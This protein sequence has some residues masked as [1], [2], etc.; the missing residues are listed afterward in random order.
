MAGEDC[1]HHFT[2][3][4]CG[5]ARLNGLSKGAEEARSHSLEEKPS[6]V[7]LLCSHWPKQHN[8]CLSNSLV[9]PPL[10]LKDGTGAQFYFRKVFSVE[11]KAIL[12]LANW[13][14]SRMAT[15]Y[16]EWERIRETDWLVRNTTL[17]CSPKHEN[18]FLPLTKA[19]C[20]LCTCPSK[21]SKGHVLLFGLVSATQTYHALIC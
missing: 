5:V 17:P 2:N 18:A 4:N 15:Q 16:M 1:N 9:H 19:Y 21:L 11:M 20:V 12:S 3:E 8:Q 14:H 7:A 10:S 6:R 13:N